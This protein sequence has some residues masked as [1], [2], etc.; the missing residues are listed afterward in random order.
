M[1]SYSLLVR[2]A[3]EPEKI[4]PFVVIA[5]LRCHDEGFQERM[6]NVLPRY[7]MAFRYYFSIERMLRN[8]DRSKVLISPAGTLGTLYHEQEKS[9]LDLMKPEGLTYVLRNMG[10]LESFYQEV[11]EDLQNFIHREKH[12]YNGLRE[13]S[14]KYSM[15]KEFLME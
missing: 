13:K 7:V 9:L 2:M 15:K 11:H 1:E 5:K 14:E 10:E 3:V 8:K 6:N 12:I 4:N